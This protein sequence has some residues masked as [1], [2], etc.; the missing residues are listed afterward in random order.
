MVRFQKLPLCSCGFNGLQFL[1]MMLLWVCTLRAPE[2]TRA[3]KGRR[4]KRGTQG[5][6]AN[7]GSQGGPDWW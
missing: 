1:F 6:Q 7:Q 4:D 2:E 3:S 5:L